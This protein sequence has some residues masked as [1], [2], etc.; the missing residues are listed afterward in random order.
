VL[1]LFEVVV[2][3][4]AKSLACGRGEVAETIATVFGRDM[5]KHGYERDTEAYAVAY[6]TRM[7]A[8]QFRIRFR[9]GRLWR[10]VDEAGSLRL[11]PLNSENMFVD[12]GR[13]GMDISGRQSQGYA[14]F[15]MTLEREMFMSNQD[16]VTNHRY[17]SS[18]TQGL[19]VMM[20]GTMRVVNGRLEAI[21]T[22]SGHYKPGAIN[23]LG[24][25]QALS[26]YGVAL[27][28]VRLYDYKA[29][30]VEMALPFMRLGMR[31]PHYV[32]AQQKELQRRA[33][34][35]RKKLT[36]AGRKDFRDKPPPA[37]PPPAVP[38]GSAATDEIDRRVKRKVLHEMDPV[39][40]AA[41]IERFKV[42]FPE[43]KVPD[44]TA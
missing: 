32:Q 6:L 38:W 7:E 28:D 3:T 35:L 41:E 9:D 4:L 34:V 2:D 43:A 12:I 23:L 31:W 39:F 20:A 15:V 8:Q 11:K 19:P 21:R 26:M 5:A 17:H 37:P 24:C 1:A 44:V 25:L 18:Y 22:D 40:S 10:Y 16:P 14:A 29:G 42:L 30:F 27:T 36:L 33:A 13:K